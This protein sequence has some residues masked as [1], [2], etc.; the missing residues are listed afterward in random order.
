MTFVAKW[1]LANPGQSFPDKIPSTSHVTNWWNANGILCY[2]ASNG[3]TPY[4]VGFAPWFFD[5]YRTVAISFGTSGSWDYT[6][7]FT[8]GSATWVKGNSGAVQGSELSRIPFSFT[9]PSGSN[10]SYAVH[11]NV[12]FDANYGNL[13]GLWFDG[14]FGSGAKQAWLGAPIDLSGGGTVTTYSVNYAP[15]TYGDWATQTFANLLLGVPT[16]AFDGTMVSKSSDWA[17]DGWNPQ[18]AGTVAGN[19]TY[20]AQWKYIGQAQPDPKTYNNLSNKGKAGQSFT[21]GSY[22]AS[23]SGDMVVRITGLDKNMSIEITIL[24]DGSG[25]AANTFSTSGG[26]VQVSAAPGKAY[27]VMVKIISANGN[28]SYTVSVSMP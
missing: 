11:N 15:G 26:S 17:F 20:T 13:L 5:V 25:V 23:V 6:A 18:V 9:A 1:A 19:A 12:V 24:E 21:H 22:A 27:S 16:P 8:F 2:A 7:V 28:S 3:D 10:D 4:F 14:P